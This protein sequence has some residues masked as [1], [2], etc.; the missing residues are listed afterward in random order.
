MYSDDEIKILSFKEFGLE[1]KVIKC[2]CHKY[3]KKTD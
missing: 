2:L 1:E 3:D